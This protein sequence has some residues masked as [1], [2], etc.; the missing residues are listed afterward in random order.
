MST[1]RLVC[2]T[3][4]QAIEDG[5]IVLQVTWGMVCDGVFVEME[6]DRQEFQHHHEN[7][8]THIWR[9]KEV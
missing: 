8:A 6:P 1:G 2:T 4:G 5:E 7:C 3:C 9:D